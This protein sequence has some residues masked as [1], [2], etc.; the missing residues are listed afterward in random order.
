MLHQGQRKTLQVQP[1]IKVFFGPVQ[2][3]PPEFWIGVT[4]SNVEPAL[5]S[6]LKLPAN[7]GLI[8]TEVIEGGPAARA[9]LKVNDILLT[10]AEKP[11]KDQ[12]ALI[13]LVQKYGEKSVAAEIVR[14][15]SRQTVQVTPDA[16]RTALSRQPDGLLRAT[17]PF[18]TPASCIRQRRVHRF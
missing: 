11:L 18:F 8:A 4:V 12:A 7:Q 10:M 5:R 17:S 15:G 9:G 16:G 13:D 1:H 2:P 14:E 3:A 6:Q